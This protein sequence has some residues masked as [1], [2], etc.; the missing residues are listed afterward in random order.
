MLYENEKGAYMPKFIDLT[1]ERFGRLVVIERAESK[2]RSNGRMRTQWLC[3]CDCGNVAIVDSYNLRKGLQVSCGCFR[4]EE[5]I[6]RNTTHGKTDSRAY[7]VWSAM[8]SRCSNPNMPQYKYY[9]GRGIYVCDEWKNSFQVFNQW[10]MEHG[11]DEKAPRGQY[12]VDRIDPNEPYCPENCR[13]VTQLEQANNLRSNRWIECNGEKHTLAEWGR[14]TGIPA[15]KIRN[16]LDLL[17]WTPE[18]ALHTA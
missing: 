3:Q 1:G 13:L 10:L 17:G 4:D 16:R 2:A 14:I 6:R 11:Y 5:M 18:K 8:K 15:M 12:T 9:G 7:R